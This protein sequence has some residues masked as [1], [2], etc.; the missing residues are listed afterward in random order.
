MRIF[1]SAQNF[2]TCIT[3]KTTKNP[4]NI[5]DAPKKDIFNAVVPFSKAINAPVATKKQ[6]VESTAVI[7]GDFIFKFLAYVY[8]ITTTIHT[9][10]QF[11]V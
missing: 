3:T 2:S 5:P 11:I 1:L 10:K 9:D 8:A 7:N 4:V 6:T